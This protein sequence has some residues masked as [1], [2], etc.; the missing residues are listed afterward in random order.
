MSLSIP[1]HLQSEPWSA[2]LWA[3]VQQYITLLEQHCSPK[4]APFFVDV[5]GNIGFAAIAFQLRYH[6]QVLSI[7]AIPETYRSLEKNCAR[8]PDIHTRQTAIG[9]ET[10]TLHLYEYPLARGLGGLSEPTSQIWKELVRAAIQ[11]Q[12]ASSIFWRPFQWIGIFFWSLFAALIVLTRRSIPLEQ[13][14][15]S[16]ILAD[17]P[18]RTIDVLKIDIE[19][20]ELAALTGIK[21]GDWMRIHTI[22]I[23]LHPKQRSEILALMESHHFAILKEEPGPV[24]SEHAPTVLLAQ[25]TRSTL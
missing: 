13:R 21:Q 4:E 6:A 5:G 14:P 15:L 16:D 20:H 22:L 1:P 2:L 19:G 3:D 24:Q 7:E 9:S 18:D 10:G 8:Y 11:S 17:Y 23:E 25:N 12:P